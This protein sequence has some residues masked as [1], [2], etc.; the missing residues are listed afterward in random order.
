MP[1]GSIGEA[2]SVSTFASQA[3]HEIVV[4]INIGFGDLA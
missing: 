1:V 2:D 4:D 3:G